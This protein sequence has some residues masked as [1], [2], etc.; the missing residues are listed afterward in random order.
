MLNVAHLVRYGDGDLGAL[1][2][3]HRLLDAFKTAD[4]F[5]V[6][7][8]KLFLRDEVVGCPERGFHHAT[9]RAEERPCAGILAEDAVCLALRKRIEVDPRNLDHAGKLAGGEDDVDIL[10]PRGVHFL[11]ACNLVFLRGAGHDGNHVQLRG[12]QPHLLGKVGLRHNAEHLLR[13]LGG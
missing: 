7:V 13:A 8:R 4:G 6:H 10:I 11:R 9:G 5:E 1:D 3:D 12:I 2:V